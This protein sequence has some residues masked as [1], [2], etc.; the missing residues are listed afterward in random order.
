MAG[1]FFS[2][3]WQTLTQEG[4]LSLLRA[5]LRRIYVRH[6]SIWYYL[7]LDENLKLIMPDFD[8][9]LDFDNPQR[10]LDWIY[11][12]EIPGTDDPVEITSMKERGHFFVGIMDGENLIGYIKLGFDQVYVFDYS[13]DI[14]MPPGDFFVMDIYVGPEMRRRGAGPFLVTAAS[15]EMRN[16]GFKRGVMHVQDHVD[17]APMHRT[18]VR[19]GYREIGRVDYRLICG[20]KIFRPHPSTFLGNNETR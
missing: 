3:V 14:Q 13:L 8:G 17:K 2:R 4:L 12:R 19:T 6:K 9:W 10:V 1:S 7:P 20:R 16:R 11:T 18:C 15:V 5:V